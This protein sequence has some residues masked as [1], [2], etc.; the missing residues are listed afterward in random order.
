MI[1]VERCYKSDIDRMIRYMEN[2]YWEDVGIEDVAKYLGYDPRYC[3]LLFKTCYGENLGEYLRML[4]ME[5]AK[6][7][8]RSGAPVG[9]VAQSLSYKPRGFFYTFQSYFGTSPSQYARTG[10]TYGQYLKRYDY[11]N[12][13]ACWARQE[14]PTSDGLWEFAYFDPDTREYSLMTWHENRRFF[15]IPETSAT[16]EDPNHYCRHRLNG[17]GMHPGVRARAVKSFRCPHGG[18]VDV[19]FSVGRENPLRKD[20]TPCWVQ[21]YHNDRP[22]GEPVILDSFEPALLTASVTVCEG[23]RI[24]LHLDAMGNRKRDGIW[25]FRQEIRYTEITE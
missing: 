24:R 16:Y 25:L 19:F 2:H 8:L 11:R 4:R 5:D 7:L 22:L 17:Y 12:S 15:H 10:K 18:K 20:D 1:L 9:R 3:N 6:D 23:D 21:L 14:N 13:E